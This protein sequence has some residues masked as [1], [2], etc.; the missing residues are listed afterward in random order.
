MNRAGASVESVWA[1]MMVRYCLLLKRSKKALMVYKGPI[2]KLLTANKPICVTLISS[3]SAFFISI[4][5]FM[6]CCCL[7]CWGTTQVLF[8]PPN[9]TWV[10][11]VFAVKLRV[12]PT[13]SRHLLVFRVGVA[14]VPFLEP[15]QKVHRHSAPEQAQTRSQKI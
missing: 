1:L 3:A 8:N 10:P 12:P 6:I 5:S 9:S 4:V 2:M 15:C 11:G 13:P 7:V 14:M